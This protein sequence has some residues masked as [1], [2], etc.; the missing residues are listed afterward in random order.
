MNKKRIYKKYHLGHYTKL[1]TVKLN[2]Y[3]IGNCKLKK[4]SEGIFRT[5]ES[6]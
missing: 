3:E 1:I 2:Q 6:K 5:I 4:K